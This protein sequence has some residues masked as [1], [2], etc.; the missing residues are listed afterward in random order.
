MA[1]DDMRSLI[2]EDLAG[3]PADVPARL[4]AGRRVMAT[5]HENP[6]GDA[7]GSALA[8]SLALESRGARVDLVCA[9]PVPEM[10]DASS[11]ARY[12]QSPATSSGSAPRCAG[13]PA[14][15]RAIVSAGIRS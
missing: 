3:V 4:L 7:L 14:V 8:I 12:A 1:V 9:D 10:Y 11:D 13:I 15:T 6:D 2:A 5:C